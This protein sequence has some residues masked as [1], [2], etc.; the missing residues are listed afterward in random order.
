MERLCNGRKRETGRMPMRFTLDT[1]CVVT[2]SKSEP[3][4]PPDQIAALV[5]LVDLASDGV[6][7][8]QLAAAYDRDFDRYKAPDGRARQLAWLAAAPIAEPRVSGLFVIG[9]SVIEGP[10]VIAS[11]EEASL[12][13]DIRAVLDPAFDGSN[14]GDEPHSR[15]AKR[16]SDIDHLI[17]HGRSGAD[18]FVTLD[19]T[20]ILVHRAR[21]ARLGV[22]VCW[23]TEAVTLADGLL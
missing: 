7:E 10:D 22:L 12:Y 8:L 16:T 17:A 1:A 11:D 3:D 2:L 9:V 5:Q 13:D 15:L 6:I 23:P 4:T 21:L 18:A 14:L 19:D 20:T